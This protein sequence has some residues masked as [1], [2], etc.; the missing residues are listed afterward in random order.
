MHTRAICVD[1]RQHRKIT[2]KRFSALISNSNRT[3]WRTIQEVIGQVISNQPSAL[4]E[5]DL[6]S[7]ALL[8][9]KL[10]DVRSYYQLTGKITKYEKVS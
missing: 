7:L 4:H 8:L 10:Y 2:R 6:K 9:P 1:A 5:D 3:E